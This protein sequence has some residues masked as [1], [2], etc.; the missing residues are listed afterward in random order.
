MGRRYG[1]GKEGRWRRHGRTTADELGGVRGRGRGRERAEVVGGRVDRVVR[2]SSDGR[3]RVSGSR[4]GMLSTRVK[5][6][7]M[8]VRIY[9]CMLI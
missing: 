1:R 7:A 6:V 2:K 8:Q 5:S 9:I 3:G 4:I